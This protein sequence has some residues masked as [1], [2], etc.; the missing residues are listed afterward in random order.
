[1]GNA[2]D[3]TVASIRFERKLLEIIDEVAQTRATDRSAFI[4][5]CVLLRLADLGYLSEIVKKALGVN[6]E[7]DKK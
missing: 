2:N 7:S 1:M 5:E 6:S 4:R 3:T